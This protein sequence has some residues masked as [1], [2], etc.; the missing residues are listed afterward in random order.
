[1]HKADLDALLIPHKTSLKR[2]TLLNGI[3][4]QVL[5]SIKT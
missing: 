2:I 4:P 1:M 3:T 5:S